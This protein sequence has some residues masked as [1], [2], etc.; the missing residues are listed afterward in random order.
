[1][2]AKQAREYAKQLLTKVEGANKEVFDLI[3]LEIKK[4]IEN[5][6]TKTYLITELPP[7]Q[8]IAWLEGVEYETAICQTGMNEQSLKISWS[9]EGLKMYGND[10]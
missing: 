6:P 1:M 5:D 10:R 2:N 3:V 7:K 9:E 8:V 4:S